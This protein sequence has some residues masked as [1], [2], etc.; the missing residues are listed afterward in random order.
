MGSKVTL[1]WDGQDS[2]RVVDVAADERHRP[3]CPSGW[4]TA[5]MPLDWSQVP[6]GAWIKV[7]VAAADGRAAAEPLH[8]RMS[9]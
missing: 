8:V 4:Q 5:W 3:T 7:V 9:A 2:P 1:T 6:A